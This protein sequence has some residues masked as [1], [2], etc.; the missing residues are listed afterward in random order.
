[1][2]KNMLIMLHK[3][4]VLIMSATKRQ[5]NKNTYSISKLWGRLNVREILNIP[6]TAFYTATPK[7]L[8]RGFLIIAITTLILLFISNQ[9]TDLIFKYYLVSDPCSVCEEIKRNIII[10]WSNITITP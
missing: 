5:Y 7:E 9:L 1:M 2:E 6:A 10:N 8:F 4:G 3:G